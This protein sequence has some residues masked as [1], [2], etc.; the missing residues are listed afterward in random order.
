VTGAADPQ[1]GET[2]PRTLVHL[3]EV[4]GTVFRIE[5][6]TAAVPE[7]TI[8]AAVALLHHID[9]VF[10]TYRPDSAI[11]RL[12][13]REVTLRDCPE[14]VR[15][16]AGLCA[17]AYRRTGG[18]FTPTYGGGYDPTGLVKGWSV[19]EVHRLLTAA[20]SVC[21]SINGGG[22]VRVFGRLADGQ[23][24]RV[25]ITHPLA[26][27][28]CLTAVSGTDLAVAS[29]GS[30]ERGEH[31]VNPFTGRVATDLAGVSVIAA[32]TAFADAFATAMMAMGRE[33]IPWADRQLDL[34]AVSVD[35]AGNVAFTE[36]FPAAAADEVTAEAD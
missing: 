35:R 4:M 30:Y 14:E 5:I 24:W 33:A 21:H 34:E 1:P 31:V 28:T 16:V 25:G 19:D 22:D 26:P 29:S 8:E 6:G 2:P 23:P 17:E 11:S 15:E 7:A 27:H 3:E 20:G 12:G 36:G 9:E 32:D 13:R 18:Y 10:S